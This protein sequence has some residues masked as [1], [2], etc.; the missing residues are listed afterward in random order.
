MEELLMEKI[1][2]EIEGDVSFQKRWKSIGVYLSTANYDFGDVTK[3]PIILHTIQ[4]FEI[5]KNSYVEYFEI[6]IQNHW[7]NSFT[8]FKG[9]GKDISTVFMET[10]ILGLKACIFNTISSA[11]V[12]MYPEDTPCE[13][14]LEATV[15]EV[16]RFAIMYK[17]LFSWP[18]E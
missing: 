9:D 3:H 8:L 1:S 15:S 17:P 10:V 16:K 6:L 5:F 2:S 18:K 14:N 7:K 11:L 4:I 13:G 12:A